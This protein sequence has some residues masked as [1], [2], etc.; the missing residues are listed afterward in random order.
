MIKLWD[1]GK[2]YRIKLDNVAGTEVWA[3]R[4]DDCFVKSA[5]DAAAAAAAAALCP[6]AGAPGGGSG[7]GQGG[8]RGLHPVGC[9]CC[10]AEG[11]MEMSNPALARIMGVKGKLE[12][13]LF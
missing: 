10:S 7:F 4:D 3:P 11:D 9:I 5:A 8:S 12:G 2:A 13:G 6:P 1:G